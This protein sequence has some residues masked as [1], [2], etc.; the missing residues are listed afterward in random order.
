MRNILVKANVFLN[1]HKPASTMKHIYIHNPTYTL[2][3]RD[4]KNFSS[5]EI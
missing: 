5:F 2:P 3:S 1:H 4:D